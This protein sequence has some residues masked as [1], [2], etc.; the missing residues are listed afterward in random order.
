MLG[1]VPYNSFS[2]FFFFFLGGGGG[3]EVA[4]LVKLVSA[5]H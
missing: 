5:E 2:L 4:Q 3:H 1:I